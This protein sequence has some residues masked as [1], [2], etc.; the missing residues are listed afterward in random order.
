MHKIREG[1]SLREVEA[2]SSPSLINSRCGCGMRVSGVC[3]VMAAPRA[4]A[5]RKEEA[6]GARG[7]S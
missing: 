1:G 2:N 5:V 6:E 4:V 3:R 7:E